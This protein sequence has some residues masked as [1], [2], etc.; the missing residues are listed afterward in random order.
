MDENELKTQ[1]EEMGKLQF[2]DREISTIVDVDIETLV[3]KYGNDIDRGRLLAEAEVRQA[4]LKAAKEGSAP[5]Q[6]QF[7]ELNKRA[8]TT[9]KAR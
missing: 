3:E 1:I 9:A 5:A 7:M 4:V 8:K 2:T 6:K